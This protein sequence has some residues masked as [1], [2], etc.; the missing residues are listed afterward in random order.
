M[1]KTVFGSQLYRREPFVGICPKNHP[2]AGREVSVEE[3]RKETLIHR[4]KG[5]GTLAI[6]KEK[7]LE[8]NESLER[9]H[10]HIC[11]SSFKMIIDLIKSGYG[12]SFVY[13]ILAKSDPELG[14][15]TLKGEPIVREF[16]VIYLKHA[17]VREK[18]EWFYDRVFRTLLN[19]LKCIIYEDIPM[20]KPSLKMACFLL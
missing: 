1:T 14:I 9:F 20:C 10:R 5:S 19:C 8:H 16:N 12:I 18:M 7:L 2:F 13:E 11:I 15:F 6:L 17:D 4:E 3:I